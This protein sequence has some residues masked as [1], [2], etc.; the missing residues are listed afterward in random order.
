MS[1]PVILYNNLLKVAASITVTS[2]ATGYEK[3][4]AYDDLTWDYWKP[5]AAGTVY[6][7]VD[8]GSVM[9]I[10][11]WGVFAHDLGSNGGN[12]TLQQSATGAWSGEETDV[13]S[14]VSPAGTEP[15]LKLPASFD[16]RYLRW[17]IVSASAA[18]KIG[19]LILGQKLS[20]ESD[21][22]PGYA[23]DS[24]APRYEPRINLSDDASFL[25][26]SV[27]RVPSKG[28]MSWDLLDPDW[29]RNYWVPFLRHVELGGGFL[30]LPL[31][32]LYPDEVVY[33]KADK[34]IPSPEYTQS[35]FMR[36]ELG[37]IGVTF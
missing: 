35:L 9:T 21:L 33:A 37:Y 12:I 2:E 24:M 36:G 4:R 31:P 27:R 23:P 7:T 34:N 29:A 16:A 14:A 5:S 32:D 15:I 17:K 19:G 18:S 20:V 30:Y 10:D 25:G 3:E 13:G 26:V 22:N 8:L 6:Y 11:A 28:R 1:N